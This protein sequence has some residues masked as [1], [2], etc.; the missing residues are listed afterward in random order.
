MTT[1]ILAFDTATH[2]CSAA[3]Y[4]R[5][6]VFSRFEIAP[7]EHSKLLLPMIKSILS[8][9]TITLADVQVIAFGCGPGSFMGAR[10]ATGMAQGLALGLHL[11]VISVS[12]LHLLAQTAYEE[13][14]SNVR[15]VVA[16][17]DARMDGIYWGVYLADQQGIMQPI[18]DDTLSSPEAIDINVVREI[19][20]ALVGN[21]WSV[22]QARFSSDFF[23]TCC[24]KTDL[25]P[26]AK[27]MLAIADAKFSS[28]EM[29]SPEKIGPRY[30]RHRVTHHSN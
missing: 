2:A 14:P 5:D 7:R 10:L 11:P 6:H 4:H 23:Q 17:W 26:D 21:A 8:E 18:H 1:T 25:Y 29:I 16:G 24:Q 30:L 13:T 20:C 27:A 15:Q 22:Y 9:A 3:L 28:H 19:P 12:T